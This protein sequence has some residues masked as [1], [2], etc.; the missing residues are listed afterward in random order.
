M[1]LLTWH[2]TIL[3][4]DAERSVLIHAPVWPHAAGP[5]DFSVELPE[6]FEAPLASVDRPD[7]MLEP[8]DRSGLVHF[9]RGDLYLRAV[10]GEDVLAFS[11]PHRGPWE[12][13][14]TIAAADLAT[15]RHLLEH[16]W[17]VT[18]PGGAPSA[19]PVM[20]DEGFRIDIAGHVL[21][22]SEGLPKRIAPDRFQVM[23][24]GACVDMRQLPGKPPREI[25]MRPL[26]YHRWASEAA[27]V[28]EFRATP[29]RRLK[30]PGP[31]DIISLPMTV[32]DADRDWLHAR[33]YAGHDPLVGRHVPEPVIVRESNKYVL[34]ARHIEGMV[35]DEHGVSNEIGY[36]ANVGDH[37]HRHLPMPPWMRCVGERLFVDHDALE[38]APALRGAYAVFYGGNLSNYTHWVI[39]AMLP[40]HI[41]L[42]QL[43]P[44]T[45]LL[46]PGTLRG[47]AGGTPRVCDHHEVMRQF[48][49]GDLPA[50]EIA[51]TVCRVEEVYWLDNAVI[52]A[53]PGENLRALRTQLMA[54]RRPPGPRDLHIYIARRQNRRVLNQTE[55]DPFLKRNGF[56]QYFLED[57]SIDAQI[58]L[59]RHA[60]WV[61][62]PHGAE[63]GN[64]LFCAP[65]TKVLELSPDVDFKQYF[66]VLSSKLGLLHG[67]L[68]CPTHDGGFFGDMTVDLERLRILFRMMHLRL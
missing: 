47:F 25:L 32:C 19:V 23:V 5:T 63:L 8:G 14:L 56:L 7:I 62:G 52:S 1:L 18:A 43:P 31:A 24:A 39:D 64:L 6:V 67:V 45:R 33:P 35:L 59:F 27:S 46:I 54:R 15:L 37:G 58:D 41:M 10:P 28:E 66:S 3:R 48:G 60:A 30:L 29:G 40:L 50:L 2:G 12:S 17:A 34:L 36:L 38:S 65:G 57:L 53:I 21:D 13:F 42:P 55:L 49:F 61:I 4:I 44:G 22:L 51:E 11:V 26:P 20:L 16:R 9:R 68:P